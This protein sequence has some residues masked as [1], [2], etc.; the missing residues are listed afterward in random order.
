MGLS[1][2]CDKAEPTTENNNENMPIKSAFENYK[3]AAVV[4]DSKIA[5]DIG[6]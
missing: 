6:K 3:Y 1:K 4:A 2:K 5:S